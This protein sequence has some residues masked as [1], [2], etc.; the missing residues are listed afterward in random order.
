MLS[1]VVTNEDRPRYRANKG[2]EANEGINHS[3]FLWRGNI[4]GLYEAEPNSTKKL[5]SPYLIEKVD[6]TVRNIVNNSMMYSFLF[7]YKFFID[8]FSC[9]VYTTEPNE[10]NHIYYDYRV[11]LLK[12]IDFRVVQVE[13]N[14]NVLT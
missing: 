1:A 8:A 6:H 14:W 5:V 9:I 11:E 13:T 10:V 3:S 2:K 4:I 7:I 12:E